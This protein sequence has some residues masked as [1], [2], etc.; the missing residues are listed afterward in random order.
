MF[1]QT[2]FRST[3]KTLHAIPSTAMRAFKA[4]QA[5]MC[6][7]I[8]HIIPGTENPTSIFLSTMIH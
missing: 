7:Q 2:H 1:E 3:S 5:Y 4:K 8:K 6:P